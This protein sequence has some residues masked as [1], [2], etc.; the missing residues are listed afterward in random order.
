MGTSVM[1]GKGA[2]TDATFNVKTFFF[3]NCV[4]N[5]V[6]GEDLIGLHRC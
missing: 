4:A 2:A 6:G 5:N 3:L 1:W